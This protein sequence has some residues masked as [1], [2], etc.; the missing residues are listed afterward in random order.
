MKVPEVVWETRLMWMSAVKTWDTERAIGVSHTVV[1]SRRPK[2][3]QISAAFWTSIRVEVQRKQ[4][5]LQTWC[6]L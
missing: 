3:F 1:T 5:D 4:L 6:N 2:P